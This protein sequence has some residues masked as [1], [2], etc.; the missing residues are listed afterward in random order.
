MGNY[1]F[2][3]KTLLS[4]TPMNY[5]S[6]GILLSLEFLGEIKLGSKDMEKGV[7]C[8]CALEHA[9]TLE[10]TA[11]M[12]DCIKLSCNGYFVFFS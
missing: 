4:A 5:G 6:F 9:Q 12:Y 7:S 8:P 1:I 11:H 2:K 3:S 10:M